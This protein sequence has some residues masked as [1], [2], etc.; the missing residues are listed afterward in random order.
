MEGLVEVILQRM[1]HLELVSGE[2]SVKS[3]SLQKLCLCLESGLSTDLRA[4]V[5]RSIRSFVLDWD[6]VIRSM[7]FRCLR[8][9]FSGRDVEEVLLAFSLDKLCISRL[10]AAKSSVERSQILRFIARWL[11]STQREDVVE[12]F[13][14]SLLEIAW[15]HAAATQISSFDSCMVDILI[16]ICS[17]FPVVSSR[18][19]ALRR[20]LNH[21]VSA[22]DTHIRDKIISLVVAQSRLRPPVTVPE[23]HLTA[24][25]VA[26]LLQSPL[27]TLTLQASMSA[28]FI[29]DR[30]SVMEQLLILRMDTFS[31]CR[32]DSLLHP[33]RDEI[34]ETLISVSEKRFLALFDSLDSN[35]MGWK[36]TKWIKPFCRSLLPSRRSS[37]SDV[38][39]ET[40]NQED[41]NKV[42]ENQGSARFEGFSRL[43]ADHLLIDDKQLHPFLYASTLVSIT[44]LSYCAQDHWLTADRVS[45]LASLHS[46]DSELLWLASFRK[47]AVSLLQAIE[48][49]WTDRMWGESWVGTD[50][51][52]IDLFC[53]VI[54]GSYSEIRSHQES[55]GVMWS[56]NGT[57]FGSVS[58]VRP[59]LASLISLGAHGS[60]SRLELVWNC[61]LS[62]PHDVALI[63]SPTAGLKGILRIDYGST[64]SATLDVS[65]E[66][67]QDALTRNTYILGGT[68]IA[69]Y[70]HS[71]SGITVTFELVNGGNGYNLIALSK[72]KSK[73]KAFLRKESWVWLRQ[74]PLATLGASGKA[75]DWIRFSKFEDLNRA[76]K[77]LN[78]SNVSEAKRGLYLFGMLLISGSGAAIQL[79]SDFGF[80]DLLNDILSLKKT[81][82]RPLLIACYDIAEFV[83]FSFDSSP[84][85]VPNIGVL[86]GSFWTVEK[87]LIPEVSSPLFNE[88]TNAAEAFTDRHL[89]IFREINALASS[90]HFKQNTASLNA[91]KQKNPEIFQSVPLWLAVMD[92]LR[93]GRFNLQSRRIIH[94]LFMHTF[95][96]DASFMTLDRL[97]SLAP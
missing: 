82:P 62:F 44:R 92:R 20:L 9:C 97:V 78:S 31:K 91:T 60:Q 54:E 79:C 80:I 16:C 90:V 41:T 86:D 25:I 68:Q 33:M 23:D 85:I 27:G 35:V 66:Q 84:V 17:R 46:L 47:D 93:V 24:Q 28:K 36:H 14:K 1:S 45:K 69:E 59:S 73:Q 22:F 87:Q 43:I 38:V 96:S 48:S 50:L 89:N 56:V 5:I 34:V 11:H 63:D 42:D 64:C 37:F 29:T 58:L 51:E 7:A 83:S 26:I 52:A 15:S 71:C 6:R 67:I 4:R 49:G 2:S 72:Q 32:V 55:A 19:S 39:I 65:M 53:A 3:D 76:M 75:L 21:A 70:F 30:E 61:P 13:T 81:V 10:D 77:F 94:S 40:V 95:H 57:Q 18:V 8:Y 74:S 88:S 12:F